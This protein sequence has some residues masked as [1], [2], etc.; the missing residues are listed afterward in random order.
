VSK[1]SDLDLPVYLFHEGTNTRAYDLLGCHFE[2]RGGEAGAV[3]RTWAPN[4]KA[5]SVAGD[6]NLWDDAANPMEKVSEAGVWQVFIP[7]IKEFDKYKYCVVTKRGKK[8]MKADPY[9]FH[10]ETRPGT[11][12]KAYELDGYEWGDAEWQ[13]RKAGAFD[14]YNRPM[15]IY[16][17]H[18]GSWKTYP[19]GQP[20]GYEKLAEE[21]I[22]HA[23]DMGYTHVELLPLSEYPLDE[24]WGYQATG[25]YAV[26]SRYGTPKGFMRFVD[27]C[28]MA[29]VGVILDIVPAHF[30]KDAHGLFAFDGSH[31]YEYADPTMREHPDWGTAV[32][33]FGRN[34]VRS[35]LVSNACFWADKFHVDG[36]RMDA[37]ASM[38]Y[39]DY[40]RK[41]G[42]WRPNRNGGRENLEAVELLRRMNGAVLTAFPGTLTIAEESTAWPLVTKPPGDGGLG[43]NFKWNMGWM[44]DML[45]Y[46]STDPVNR[47]GIHGSLAFSLVYAFSENFV[48][49]V[50][51]DEVVHGKRSLLGRMPG[52]Y[53]EKFASVR[54]FLGYMAAHPG[55]KLLFMGAEFG[56]FIEWDYRKALDWQL[57]EYPR[58]RELMAF[59][60]DL[61]RF[62]LEEKAFWEA[63]TGWEGFA[64]ISSGDAAQNIVSFRRIARGGDEV[65]VLCNFSPVKREG[66]R[67]GVKT[68]GV[69]TEV[70]SSDDAKYGGWENRNAPVESEE[71]PMHG[72]ERSI[73]LTLPPLSTIYLKVG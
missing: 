46:M 71:T 9:A 16:E 51:H 54:A 65:V 34:E 31:C 1:K 5:V 68:R 25:Y 61:N 67:I 29:G 27:L 24:S 36:L 32:F 50:S 55:K 33:D 62:Y 14:P 49:P 8:L 58:H 69:Y 43:F 44:N 41:P 17:L 73:A 39:L 40:S 48:L 60:R 22:P 23:L 26:T 13:A 45:R 6:F 2:R 35:F 11:A 42:Q 12:S 63:D 53:D 64:W 47:S 15:N 59:A 37:V 70:L 21:L 30:P 4:A 7:G 28:H 56:Q 66:Y 10:A 3:F 72:R 38:L 57:L 20:F 52:S 18:A 19:D